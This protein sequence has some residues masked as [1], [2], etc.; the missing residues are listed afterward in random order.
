M[1]GNILL[2]IRAKPY[3]VV[4]GRQRDFSLLPPIYVFCLKPMQSMQGGHS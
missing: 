2:A 3:G 4:N 1:N